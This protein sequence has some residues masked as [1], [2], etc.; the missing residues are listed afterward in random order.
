ME[1]QLDLLERIMVGAGKSREGRPDAMVSR[2]AFNDTVY[3]DG[4]LSAKMKRLI[5][6]AIGLRVGVTGCIIYQTKLAVEAGASK[7][8]VTEAVL[9]AMAMGGTTASSESWRVGE[10]LEEMGKL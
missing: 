5:A 8:E 7:E 10:T 3:A 9:V 4:V 1:K 6:L 2:D